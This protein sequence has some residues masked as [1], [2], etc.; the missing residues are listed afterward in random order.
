MIYRYLYHFY[1]FVNLICFY[2]CVLRVLSIL[3]ILWLVRYVVCIYFLPLYSLSFPIIKKI[4]Y[5]SFNFD[6]VQFI[7]YS[8]KLWFWVNFNTNWSTLRS[9]RILPILF[10][11]SYFALHP[12]LWSILT[13]FLYKMWGLSW[14]SFF[15]CQCISNCYS[16]F[17][18]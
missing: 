9:R 6:E 8:Y 1:P 11:K 18:F 17:V 3:L 16:I 4:F 7:N 15:F 12:I 10:S 13:S 14:S 5:K 2:F